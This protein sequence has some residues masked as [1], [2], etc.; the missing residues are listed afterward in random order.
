[1]KASVVMTR[2]IVVVSPSVT[3]QGAGRMMERKHIRH[4]PVV[5]GE[6]L[7]GI[8][9]DRDLLRHRGADA[10]VTC[11]EVMTEAPITCSPRASVGRVAELM[12][13]LKIDSIPIV[14]DDRLVGLVTSSDL[15]A[16]LVE[17]DQAQALPFDYRLRHSLSD[18]ALEA[19]A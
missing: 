13:E 17:R 19:V 7:V 10:T 9:S 12:I 18:A 11:G 8:V 14:D 5:A 2:E 3:L 15:L 6:R 4:L 16:L 1:M